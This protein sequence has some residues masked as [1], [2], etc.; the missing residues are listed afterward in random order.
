MARQALYR[1][2]RPRTFA[3]IVG[4]EHI[5]QTLENAI[6]SG[7][8]SHAYL[9]TGPHGVGKTSTARIL[10]HQVN[11]FEYEDDGTTHL[12]IIEIDA[13]SNRRIDEIR[14]LRDKIHIAPS[15]GNFKIYIIDEVHMLTR[16]AFNA[17]LKTLEEPPIH[18]IFILATTEAHK[19]PATIVSRTQRY[20]FRPVKPERVAGYLK[21][22]AEAEK[23]EIDDDALLLLAEYGGGSLR[24]ATSLLDQMASQNKQINTKYIQER[25]GLLD[26]ER[27]EVLDEAIEAGNIAD[28]FNL[29][30]SMYDNGVTATH[31]AETLINYWRK[32]IIE[33]D[34]HH[35]I[36]GLEKLLS[37]GAAR[38]PIRQ[39][40]A[41]LANLTLANK[42]KVD[43][44]A[45]PKPSPASQPR[46]STPVAPPAAKKETI[47][48]LKNTES[49]TPAQTEEGAEAVVNK[50]NDILAHA[51]NTHPALAS[52]LRQGTPILNGGLT[53]EFKYPL[54]LRKA[55]QPE[56]K[57][58]LQKSIHA[59]TG[60]NPAF[61]LAS[62]DRGSTTVVSTPAKQPSPKSDGLSKITS[63][64]GGDIIDLKGGN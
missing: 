21:R 20:G 15:S 45:A 19:L 53:I 49:V 5:T 62:G 9:F 54:H 2:Y 30:E 23:I 36:Q 47:K 40:E 7:Q 59:I 11:D 34:K 38:S 10:A 63:M 14:E 46:E 60:M 33:A 29:L 18:A 28:V 22:I 50:W 12:D 3:D 8:L 25:L 13:A 52:A 16:E 24:D 55:A 6:T 51:K 42:P 26:V 41:V 39:L 58:V 35:K 43:S 57:A 31:V 56:N 4:Q 27:V 17:L 37:V 32:N 61:E 48:P 44:V 64:L 1:K